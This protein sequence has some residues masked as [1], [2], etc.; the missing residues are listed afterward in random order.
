MATAKRGAMCLYKAYNFRQKDP[1]IDELRTV[2]QDHFGERLKRT[3]LKIVEE[4]GGPRVGTTS[5]WFFGATRIP[6]SASI[7]A[8]GRSLGYRRRWVKMR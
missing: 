2:L 6:K 3:H 1:A 4:N 5:R 7:E 8:T